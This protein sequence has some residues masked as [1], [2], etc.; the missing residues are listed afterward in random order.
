MLSRPFRLA[1]QP[2]ENGADWNAHLRGSGR[3]AIGATEMFWLALIAAL[4]ALATS[5]AANPSRG[6]TGDSPGCLFAGKGG[7]ICN[8]SAIAAQKLATENGDRCLSFGRGGRYCPPVK[9]GDGAP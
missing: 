7:V 1:Y 3:A 2:G 8:G 5:P 9:L 6:L 4:V